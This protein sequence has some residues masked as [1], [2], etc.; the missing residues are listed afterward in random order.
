M[1]AIG[2]PPS[3]LAEPDHGEAAI[4]RHRQLLPDPVRQA[5]ARVQAGDTTATVASEL[6]DEEGGG[7]AGYPGA[8]N[9]AQ[10]VSTRSVASSKNGP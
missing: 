10:A 2:G 5:K 9:P 8:M 1:S 3:P 4:F 6:T 7:P